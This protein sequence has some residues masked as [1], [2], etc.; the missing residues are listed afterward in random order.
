[1]TYTIAD[2]FNVAKTGQEWRLSAS[3]I[4]KDQTTVE[5]GTL[6]CSTFPEYLREALSNTVTVWSG[7][8]SRKWPT[9]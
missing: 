6:V 7:A 9:N 2:N 1:M 4:T 3:P 8:L 5:E